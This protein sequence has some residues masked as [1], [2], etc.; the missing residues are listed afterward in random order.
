MKR[1]TKSY[2][3]STGRIKLTGIS[4]EELKQ[5]AKKKEGH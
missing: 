1:Y 3:P 5:K 4:W 2:Y